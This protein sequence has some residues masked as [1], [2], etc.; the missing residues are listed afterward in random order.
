MLALIAT[1][2]FESLARQ[3]AVRASWTLPERKQRALVAEIKQEQLAL[4]L[5]QRISPNEDIGQERTT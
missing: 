1:P 5:S 3:H 4:L 2:A